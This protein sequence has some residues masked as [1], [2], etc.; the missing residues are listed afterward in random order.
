MN[1]SALDSTLHWLLRTSLEASVLILAVLGL[2]AV[3]GARLGPAW[4]I[5]LWVL[6]GLKLLLPACIPAGFGLGG[7]GQSALLIPPAIEAAASPGEASTL[8]LAS[9][10]VGISKVIESV[11]EPS[12]S[13]MQI[14]A[15]LWLTGALTVVGIAAYRQQRFE[16]KLRSSPEADHPQLLALLRESQ[17]L[18]GVTGPVS[19]LILSPGSTPAITG[20]RTPR[21]LLPAD[22]QS[23]FDEASLRHVLLHELMHVRH[24]DLLWNWA[25]LA[26]QALHWFNPLVWIIGSRF[27]SDRELRC[28][29][30]VL[31][32]LSP[33][34]RLSYGHT[35][36]RI[37]ETF[38]AP[39]A[40]AGLAPC[41][42]NHPT[43][44]QRITMIAR[45]HRNRP[46]LQAVFTLAFGVITCYAFTTASASAEKDLPAKDRSREGQRTSNPDEKAEA[47]REGD[48]SKMKEGKRDGEGGKK[49]GTGDRVGGPK[50]GPRD[51]DKPRTGAR[52]GDRPKTGE[53]DGDKPRTGERDGDRPKTGERDGDKPRTGERD[54]DKGRES[55]EGKA[56][57]SSS[58]QTLTLRVINQ[59]NTVLLAGEEVPMNRLRGR[60]QS[61]LPEHP[62]APVIINAEDDVP[63]KALT[64]VLDAVRD[65]G[66][67]NVRISAE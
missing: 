34:E 26:V 46:W 29:A 64:G 24:R 43:L 30:A 20:L 61:Y 54:G 49:P 60:L 67:K 17:R 50:I 32:L 23:C 40:I 28:D 38:F 14:M 56:G 19:I 37:Q 51:G 42:R 48:G 11:S 31:R 33:N 62:G 39:P 6:V 16:K 5:G 13:W 12:F 7:W 10:S 25:T 4:R 53:R 36:L 66:N 41:V 47:P 22:W 45:P 65:N 15:A 59:G 21:L 44:L 57:R 1:A 58:Q 63:Y 35:L 2:R 52:D 3:L 18:T 27:Q 8:S 55:A 9:T